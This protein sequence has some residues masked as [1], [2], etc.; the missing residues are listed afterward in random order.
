MLYSS[1]GQIRN[2]RA[3][4]DKVEIS[5]VQI[6]EVSWIFISGTKSKELN[7]KFFSPGGKACF[8]RTGS[9]WE[10]LPWWGLN[11]YGRLNGFCFWIC[12]GQHEHLNHHDHHDDDHHH[13]RHHHRHPRQEFSVFASN[14]GQISMAGIKLLRLARNFETRML[15]IMMLATLMMI[16]TLME[17]VS[18]VASSMCWV[19]LTL[20]ALHPTLWRFFSINISII[21]IITFVLCTIVDNCAFKG[22]MWKVLSGLQLVWLSPPLS[23]WGRRVI[24]I[25]MDLMI[26]IVIMVIIIIMIW[27]LLNSSNNFCG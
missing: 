7:V 25:T 19:W 1:K 18:D 6:L 17:L 5:R 10:I 23:F 27:Y 2:F 16:S 4:L 3:R 11:D 12:Q 14:F 26:I 20:T 21:F 9:N 22:E 15:T 8:Q 13:H 24:M